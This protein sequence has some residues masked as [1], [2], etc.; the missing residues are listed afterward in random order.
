M[1]CTVSSIVGL[2]YLLAASTQAQADC[3]RALTE[4][5]VI[6]QRIVE[7]LRPDKAGQMRMFAYDGS[8]YTA[9]EALWMKRHLRMVLRACAQGDEA[10]AAA[11]LRGVTD[12]LN[13][14]H[15]AS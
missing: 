3:S 13:A 4:Q 8:E 1:T 10:D 12:L 2:T 15:R 7:S 6:V 14:R 11:T 5:C 9:A